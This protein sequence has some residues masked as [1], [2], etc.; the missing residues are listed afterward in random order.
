MKAPRLFPVISAILILLIATLACA[1]I[2]PTQAPAATNTPAPAPAPTNT[3]QPTSTEKPSPTS[4]VAAT[5]RA[6]EFNSVLASFAEKGY[7]ESTQGKIVELDPFKE[8]WAQRGWYK[9]WPFEKTDSDFL[10][11]SHYKWSTASATPEISGC[12]IVFGIQDNGD[13]Y[14]VFLDKSRIDFMMKRGRYAY[15]VG[16]TKGSGRVNFGNPAEADFAIS[17][18]GQSAYISVNGEFTVYT[19]SKDQTTHGDFAYSLISGT[20]SDYG[21][22]CEMTG[23]MLWTPK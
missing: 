4:D 8:D 20:N 17:V 7:V 9:W 21:T 14:S 6:D 2:S 16:K 19:L 15:E 1:S 22:R 11:K 5:Q 10:F 12:G 3:L 23:S 18:K 13:H